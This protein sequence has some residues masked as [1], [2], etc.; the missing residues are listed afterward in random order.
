M[1]LTYINFT[2]SAVY[3]LR[4]ESVWQAYDKLRD[5]LSAMIVNRSVNLT[6]EDKKINQ[7]LIHATKLGAI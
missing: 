5:S 2:R 4:M 7:T 3:D 6:Q 1:T